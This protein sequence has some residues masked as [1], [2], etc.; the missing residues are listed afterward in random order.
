MDVS[1]ED[2]LKLIGSKEVEIQILRTKLR[3]ALSC[4]KELEGGNREKVDSD[5]KAGRKN[6]KN[7]TKV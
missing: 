4:V 2:L 1:T 6:T 7:R 3:E 5:G